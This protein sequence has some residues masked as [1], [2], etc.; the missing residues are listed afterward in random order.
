V[1]AP[2]T[3]ERATRGKWPRRKAQPLCRAYAG[4]T[5]RFAK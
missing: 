5:S 4:K 3:I 2:I 1:M